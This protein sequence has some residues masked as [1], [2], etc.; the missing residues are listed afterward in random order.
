MLPAMGPVLPAGGD[1]SFWYESDTGKSDEFMVQQGL[2]PCRR[3]LL[4]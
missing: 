2:F 1:S 4:P 3:V